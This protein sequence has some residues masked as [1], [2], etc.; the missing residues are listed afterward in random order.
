MASYK[1][2][3]DCRILVVDD[4]A[5]M[6]RCLNRLLDQEQGFAICGEAADGIQ[7]VEQARFLSPDAIVMDVSMPNMDGLTA[8]KII[9]RENPSA[10][11]VVV[12]QQDPTVLTKLTTRLGLEFV[13]KSDLIRHLVPT[14]QQLMKYP[15]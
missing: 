3:G 15:S 4:N 9:R 1:S 14:L 6:R 12:S 11:I 10:R 7:A 13:A 5:E 8:A 2:D